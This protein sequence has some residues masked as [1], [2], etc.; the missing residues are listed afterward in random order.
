MVKPTRESFPD[1]PA[2]SSTSPDLQSPHGETHTRIVPQARPERQNARHS[3]V[4]FQERMERLA[5]SCGIPKPPSER[6]ERH[7][8]RTPRRN[9]RIERHILERHAGTPQRNIT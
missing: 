8:H 4:A 6:Q 2:T 1:P 7:P 5:I 3:R 9:A